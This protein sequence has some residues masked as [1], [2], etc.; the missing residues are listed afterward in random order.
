MSKLSDQT[1]YERETTITF[2]ELEHHAVLWTA[3]PIVRKEWESSGYEVQEF[4]G[5]WKSEVPKEKIAF[6]TLSRRGN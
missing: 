1:L 4:G 5:G 6:K 2:N 3:S